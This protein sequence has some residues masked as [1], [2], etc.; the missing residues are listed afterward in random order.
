MSTEEI[1]RTVIDGE[2]AIL[3]RLASLVAQ[4]I[5]AGE[6]I[7][8]VNAEK[9]IILGEPNTTVKK[10]K[11]KTKIKTKS[12]PLRGPFFP[13]TTT[14]IVKRAVRGMIPYKKSNG[15]MAYKRLRVYAE[16]P[17]ELLE[18]EK[19]VVKESMKDNLQCKY[20]TVET[21]ANRL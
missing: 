5:L 9:M 20:M 2:N 1:T 19:I 16:I 12:N 21:L 11:R 8:I 14:E 6:N 13:K 15:K 7:A 17:K 4:K 3:G 10:Y 18:A